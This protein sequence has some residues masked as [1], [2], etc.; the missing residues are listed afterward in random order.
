MSVLDLSSTSQSVVQQSAVTED[1]ATH[2]VSPG[3]SFDARSYVTQKG[4]LKLSGADRMQSG[5]Y[6]CTAVNE[7]GSTSK[8]IY[9]EVGIVNLPFL[10]N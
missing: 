6:V 4:E 7:A 1:S 9:I 10:K 5:Y 3:G 8:R 2:L